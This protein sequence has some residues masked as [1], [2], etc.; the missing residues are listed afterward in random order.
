MKRK[1]LSSL[2]SLVFALILILLIV[3]SDEVGECV[4]NSLVSSVRQV[5]PSLFAYLA[6]SKII[7]GLDLFEPIYRFIPTERL[8]SLPRCSAAA[9]LTGLICGFP[10]GA[11][12]TATLYKNGMLTSDEAS[13]LLAISSCASPAFLVSVVGRSWCCRTFGYILYAVSLVS[14]VVFGIITG[15]GKKVFNKNPTHSES[16]STAYVIC[17]SISEAGIGMLSITAYITFFA[18]VR[19]IFS[20]IFGKSDVFLAVVS[21]VLEFSS[22]ALFGS[23]TGGYIGA[24]VTG[25]AVGFSSLSVFMQTA[26]FSGKY[27]ISMKYFALSKLITGTLSCV[28]GVVCCRFLPMYSSSEAVFSQSYNISHIITAIIIPTFATLSC[29]F[30]S[31]FNKF[32]LNS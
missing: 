14:V 9:I 11:S 10:T 25:F 3:F 8:F 20:I 32:R 4:R 1:L 31:K 16:I 15:R 12:C 29:T 24:A 27:K 7:I 21:A 17:S 19:Q 5:I 30:V 6:I 26:M 2:L 18:V 23:E 13:R 28:T 22:G